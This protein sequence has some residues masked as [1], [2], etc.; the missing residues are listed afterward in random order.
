MHWKAFVLLLL[1]SLISSKN[2]RPRIEQNRLMA[3]YGD[4]EQNSRALPNFV[5]KGTHPTNPTLLGANKYVNYYNAAT[6]AALMIDAFML[7]VRLLLLPCME[8]PLP[9]ARRNNYPGT[10][11]AEINRLLWPL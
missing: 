11:H 5:V 10:N 1:A 7:R 9:I 8:I 2:D 4:H 6:A 3:A